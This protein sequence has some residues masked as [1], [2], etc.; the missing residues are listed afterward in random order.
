MGYAGVAGDYGAPR[1][2]LVPAVG[3]RRTTVSNDINS[4]IS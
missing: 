2:T 1:E 3:P 4:L